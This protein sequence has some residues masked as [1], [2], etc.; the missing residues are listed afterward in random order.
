MAEAVVLPAVLDLR[1]AASLKSE[2]LARRGQPLSLDASGVDRLGGL[3]LQV[4][5]SAVRTWAADG[6]SLTVSP[7]SEAFVEQCRAFG[8]VA[9]TPALA[10][11]P[12]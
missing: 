9:L 1:A 7:A 2:L 8:A 12:A 3:S 10:G 6:Q 11:E 5:L 4:L